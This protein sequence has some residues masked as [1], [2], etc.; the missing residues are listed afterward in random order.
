MK[1][2]QPVATI[3]GVL[4]ISM[5]VLGFF[6]GWFESVKS[7]SQNNSTVQTEPALASK[8]ENVLSPQQSE[9]STLPEVQPKP[10]QLTVELTEQPP[11]VQPPVV[12]IPELTRITVRQDYYNSLLQQQP[13]TLWQQWIGL[14]EATDKN[15]QMAWMLIGYAL[16]YRLQTSQ[17][18]E[19]VYQQMADIVSHSDNSLKAREQTIQILGWTATVP[20]LQILLDET[21]RHSPDSEIRLKLLY[22]I[23]QLADVR[24]DNRFHPELSGLL[25]TAWQQVQYTDD[26]PLLLTIG[27]AIAKIGA[28]EGVELLFNSITNSQVDTPEQP[29]QVIAALK[30]LLEVRNP[31][32]VPLLANNLTAYQPDNPIFLVSGEALA[33]MGNLQA[34]KHL[35]NWATS[36][37]ESMAALTNDWFSL[38]KDSPSGNWIVTQLE[39]NRPFLNQQVKQGVINGIENSR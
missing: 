1:K 4:I 10:G 26:M 7:E 23:E 32:L 35:F 13:I 38:I 6:Q 22:A 30:A 24:W 31:V 5:M 34:T 36:A 17:N 11:V 9:S 33:T 39:E 8:P 15:H 37:P 25:E 14:L 12:E 20:A 3:A 28:P 16:P 29:P 18:Q 27:V 2:S 21:F 19:L